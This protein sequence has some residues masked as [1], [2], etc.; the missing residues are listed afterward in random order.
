MNI[1]IS[2]DDWILTLVFEE[3]DKRH[4]D[5]RRRSII[6]FSWLFTWKLSIIYFSWLIISTTSSF[7]FFSVS[8]RRKFNAELKDI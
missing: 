1:N 6:Q 8:C 2:K 3:K 7:L 5:H 4:L